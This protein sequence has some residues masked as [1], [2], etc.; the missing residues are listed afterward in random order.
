MKQKETDIS[1]LLIEHRETIKG[2]RC[3]CQELIG[4]IG[5]Q[6]QVVKLEH[7]QQISAIN[8]KKENKDQA[9][10][11]LSSYLWGTKDGAALSALLEIGEFLLKV[12]M[13]LEQKVHGL[14]QE[15]QTDNS[16]NTII[17]ESD[18]SIIN[19]FMKK[20]QDQL[21]SKTCA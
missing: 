16:G 21:L 3:I 12:I 11:R 9:D 6:V 5:Q 4:V 13:P 10:E 7:N 17:S 1:K 2:M 15:V 20:R 18:M 14:C 19:E 8:Q